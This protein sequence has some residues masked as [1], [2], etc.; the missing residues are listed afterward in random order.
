LGNATSVKGNIADSSPFQHP[1]EGDL[2]PRYEDPNGQSIGVKAPG[3]T[4]IRVSLDG[5]KTETVAG[6]IRNAY[7]IAFDTK[8][9]LFFHDSDMETDMGTTWYRPTM[10]FNVA[11]GGDYGWRSGW[12][13]FPQHFIDQVPPVVETGRGSPS[14]AALYQHINFPLRYQGAIFFADW[15]EG[16]IV[17]MR[18]ESEGAGLVGEVKTFVTG[19]P[20]NVCDVAV[21]PFGALCFCTGGRGTEGGVY[22][23][24]WKGKIPDVMKQYDSDIAR[25]IRQP[26]P[27]SAWGRQQIARLRRQ[28][29]DGWNDSITGVA[30]ESRNPNDYRIRAMD[31]MMLYGPQPTNEFLSEVANDTDPDIRAAVARL[32]GASEKSRTI[33]KLITSFLSDG[34]AMVRRIAGESALRLRI[35]P[36][37][38]TLIPMLNSYDRMEALVARRMLER[39]PVESWSEKILATDETRVFIQGATAMMIAAPTLERSYQVLARVSSFMD[40][41]VNDA[42]FIDMMRTAQLALVQ[43]KVDPTKIPAFAQRIGTEFPSGNSIINQEL[44]RLLAYLKNGQLDGRL[45]EYLASDETP[46]LDKLHV[47][48]LMQ[49]IGRTLPS[50][51]K[52]SII[53]TLEELKSSADEST[54]IAYVSRAIRDITSTIDIDQLPIILENGAEWTDAMLASLFLMPQQLDWA[55]VNQIQKIDMAIADKE[56]DT[57]DHLR[58]GIIAILAQSGDEDSMKYLRQMWEVEPERRSEISLGLA[59]SPGGENWGYL[60]SSLESLDD[61]TG[62]EVLGQLVSVSRRPRDAKH[63]RNVIAMG[64]RLRQSGLTPTVRL[65]EHW[66]GTERPNDGKAWKET[67][68]DWK[69][70]YEVT[71]P[72]AEPV[73]TGL[74]DAESSMS[75]MKVLEMLDQLNSADANRGRMIFQSAN[76]SKCHRSEGV[77]NAIGPEITKLANRMSRREMI[78]AIVNP[79]AHVADRYRSD[80]I[81]LTDGRQIEGMTARDSDNSIVVLLENGDRVRYQADEIDAIK[82]SETSPMPAGSLDGMSPQEIGDLLEFIGGGDRTAKRM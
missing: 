12:A 13:K 29:G 77:G 27:S 21:D 7:D 67:L 15:A 41:F 66:S 64:Y 31:L 42:D 17:S 81:L 49:T 40:G 38:D 35:D 30:M 16:S 62:A 52:I 23:I 53:K 55:T 9:N 59:Q 61:Q 74:D 18:T 1:Y 36:P 56:G 43:G 2:A 57:I 24:T 65:L 76:C 58:T 75:T 33:T 8:G 4:I 63:Y 28:I 3:G 45:E 6:G 73:A 14:G 37:I 44:T 60:V 11:A 68:D 26:Q 22:R 72:T 54:D 80:I 51:S 5:S 32:C 25:V 10:I 48:M 19:K 69:K 20:M 34:N 78:E 47:A 50:Q 82:A 70:W 79:N 39:I 46:N 71:F